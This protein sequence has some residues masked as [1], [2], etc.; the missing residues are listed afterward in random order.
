MKN[1]LIELCNEI[2]GNFD[3]KLELYED[4]LKRIDAEIGERLYHLKSKHSGDQDIAELEQLLIG[5]KRTHRL[6]HGKLAVIQNY[7]QDL[8]DTLSE[9]IQN[10]MPEMRQKIEDSETYEQAS[11]EIQKEAHTASDT[12]KDFFKAI[13]MWRDTPEEKIRQQA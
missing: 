6:M 9:E 11:I 4:R 8:L 13:L 1:E 12:F 7:S 3:E 2:E 10:R 5:L